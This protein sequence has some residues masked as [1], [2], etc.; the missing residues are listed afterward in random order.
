[1]KEVSASLPIKMGAG[2]TAYDKRCKS[3]SGHRDSTSFAARR[4]TIHAGT[5]NY[6]DS[7]FNNDD[8]NLSRDK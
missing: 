2:D 1:M 8:L 3:P 4:S 5:N 6:N 7:L